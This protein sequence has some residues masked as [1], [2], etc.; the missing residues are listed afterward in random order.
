MKEVGYARIST[1]K[2]VLDGQCEALLKIMPRGDIYADT[3]S[4]TI[5]AKERPG[6]TALMAA[7]KAGGV[8]TG[9][10]L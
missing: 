1:D 5:P 7:V 2:Q 8:S 3:C 4:G 9:C 6:F 10:G